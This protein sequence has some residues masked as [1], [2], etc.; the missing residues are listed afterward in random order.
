MR[1]SWKKDKILRK[2]NETLKIQLLILDQAY[3]Y[4]YH[5]VSFDYHVLAILQ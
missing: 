1:P 3:N 2:L 4:N 5:Q